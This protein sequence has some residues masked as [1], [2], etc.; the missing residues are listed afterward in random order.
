V[1]KD[2]ELRAEYD[3]AHGACEVCRPRGA[4]GETLFFMSAFEAKFQG[5]NAKKDRPPRPGTPHPDY[6]HYDDDSDQAETPKGFR[7][8]EYDSTSNSEYDSTS[9]SEYDST[10]NSGY[11]SASDSKCHSTSNSDF[12]QSADYFADHVAQDARDTLWLDGRK[13]ADMGGA[14]ADPNPDY[15]HHDDDDSDQAATPKASRKTEYDSTSNSE[16]DSTSDSKCHSTS[17]SGFERS[18]DYFADYVAQD[19]RDTLW[20]DGRKMADMGG[21]PVT[22]NINTTARRAQHHHK[23]RSVIDLTPDWK[24]KEAGVFRK[25]SQKF[26]KARNKHPEQDGSPA[27]D[28]DSSASKRRLKR[29]FS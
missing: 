23:P 13:M 19:A 15:G 26:Q 2:E 5:D 27:H 22:P 24:P 18:A 20:L 14:P 12:E 10:S 17:N 29:F 9:N 6:G 1:L 7:K 25:I 8:T 16:S 4:G 28:N 11:E 3:W 21:S